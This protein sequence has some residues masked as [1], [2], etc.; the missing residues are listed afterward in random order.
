V[1][2]GLTAA[3]VVEA[4][5]RHIGNRDAAA[6]AVRALVAGDRGAVPVT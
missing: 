3:H 6:A 1:P 4:V 2:D 5:K